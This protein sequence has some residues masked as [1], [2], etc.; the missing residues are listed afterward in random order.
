MASLSDSE[1]PRLVSPDTKEILEEEDGYL[2]SAVGKK[3]PVIRGIPRLVLGHEDYVSAFG[4]QWN[5]YRL[6]QLDSYTNTSIT[7]DRLRRCL[8]TDL[9]KRLTSH[10]GEAIQV[11]EAGC[12]AGR[13]TEIL[14]KYREV[15]LTSTDLSSAVEANLQSFPCN[16]RHRIVQCDICHA[17]FPSASFDLVVCLGVVQHTPNPER[18]IA[19]L[20]DQVKPGGFLVFDHYTASWAHYTKPLALA[21]RPVLKRLPVRMR[22]PFIENLTRI[23]FPLARVKE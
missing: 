5:R 12:G 13:F 14:L 10:H 1:F 3:Y 21:L 6:T 4:D 8:G 16:G 23:F 19:C 7:A 9:V 15:M 17:P 20:Y 11:L 18:T 22:M 2:T